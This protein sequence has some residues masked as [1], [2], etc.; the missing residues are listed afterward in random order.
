MKKT[1]L[2]LV[3]IVGL[4]IAWM[5]ATAAV[6]EVELRHGVT[7]LLETA[8]VDPRDFLA[9]DY[10]I[11]NYKISNIPADLAGYS[12]NSTRDVQKLA[13]RPIYVALHKKGKFY[14]VAHASVDP[15]NAQPGEIIVKG[16]AAPNQWTPNTIRVN[17]GLEKY[18][19]A[20]GTGNPSGKMTVRA[21]VA[22]SGDALIKDVFIDG[23]PY[24][25]VMRSQA[26]R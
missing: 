4:Q 8:P 16:K 7:V 24:A 1:S 23:K 3:V 20:E 17:Y 6:K 25:E 14:E 9:G 15:L 12:A 5:A 21:S 19:V 13:N 26:R 18:F 22:E 11:L 10:V 2:W